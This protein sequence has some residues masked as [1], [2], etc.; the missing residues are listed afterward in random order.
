MG[1]T[2]QPM[3][4]LLRHDLVYSQCCQSYRIPPTLCPA[5]ISK[6]YTPK[7]A[8]QA[9][10]ALNIVFQMQLWRIYVRSTPMMTYIN[11]VPVSCQNEA[12]ALVVQ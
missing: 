10:Y 4:D 2:F 5:L 11:P 8:T 6:G 12:S 3:V 1:F 7:H 9:L